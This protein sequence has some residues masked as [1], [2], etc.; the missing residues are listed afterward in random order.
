MCSK[1]TSRILCQVSI[2]DMAEERQLN[3]IPKYL[4]TH[5]VSIQ[6]ETKLQCRLGK[7]TRP[8]KS[9]QAR[10]CEFEL[11]GSHKRVKE[12][13]SARYRGAPCNIHPREADRQM[14]RQPSQVCK[15]QASEQHPRN[16]LF[17]ELYT[18]AML[19]YPHKHT[20]LYCK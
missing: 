5:D 20:T 11:Q 14:A 4:A 17:S 7:Y 8:E 12:N 15:Y 13:R 3:Q 2:S 9:F 16:W 10:G 18:H 6:T 1:L 19:M